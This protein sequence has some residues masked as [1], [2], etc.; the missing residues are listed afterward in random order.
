MPRLTAVLPAAILAAAPIPSQAAD[1]WLVSPRGADR[2]AVFADVESLQRS[3]GR[4]ELR[5]LRIDR[6]GRSGE[7]LETVRCTGDAGR[8]DQAA[9]H[10]FAC[11]S[12]QDRDRYGLILAGMSPEEAARLVFA[13]PPSPR[14]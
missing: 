8:P 7:R 12:D 4:V 3:D 13:L 11:A 9:L 1:W 5:T 2:T 14:S 6:T 10:R